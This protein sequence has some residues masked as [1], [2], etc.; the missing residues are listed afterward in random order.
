[1]AKIRRW[2]SYYCGLVTLIDD[3]IGK[4]MGVLDR[5]GLWDNTLIILT[6]DHGDM[7]GDYN[8]MEKGNF[9]EEVIHVPLFIVPPG[10]RGAQP[11][12]RGLVEVT[13]VAP[14]ILDYAGVPIPPQMAQAMSLRGLV[15]GSGAARET[16]LCENMDMKNQPAKCVRGERYKYICSGT[17]RQSEFYDLQE[18]PNEQVNL[19]GDPRYAAE[20]DR[21][22]DLLLD[23]LMRSEAPYHR[24]ETPSPAD[25]RAWL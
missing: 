17:G 2:R 23:R 7:A 8:M 20:I 6:T 5:R 10:S 21:H 12:V 3:M 16:I 24:D 22:K 18:D 9:Y 14:T 15:E 19:Y 4:M 25:L 11:R 13:D 1:V